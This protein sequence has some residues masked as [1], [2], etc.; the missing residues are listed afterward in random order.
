ML[1]RLLP[2][3]LLSVVGCSTPLPESPWKDDWTPAKAMGM[4][5]EKYVEYVKGELPDVR[6][7]VKKAWE[8]YDFLANVAG[9]YIVNDSNRAPLA[10]ALQIRDSLEQNHIPWFRE[11]LERYTLAGDFEGMIR[12]REA[13]RMYER[14]LQ[15]TNQRLRDFNRWFVPYASLKEINKAYDDYQKLRMRQDYFEGVVKSE[16]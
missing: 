10:L 15:E 5:Q 7:E 11:D 16:Q 3:V 8:R 12:S 9:E 14:Q 13:L 4:T 1:R 6:E 2:A